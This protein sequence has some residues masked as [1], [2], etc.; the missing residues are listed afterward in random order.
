V[1]NRLIATALRKVRAAPN[2]KPR[3]PPDA[4]LTHLPAEDREIIESALP[5]SI[6]SPARVYALVEAVR[7]CVR[8]EVVGAFAECGVWRGG[9]IVA[10]IRTLQALGASDRDIYLYDT[11]E[12]MTAP[13]EADVSP[14]DR[15]ALETWQAAQRNNS[16]PW[17]EF[18]DNA[19]FNE[20]L[21]RDTL[22]ATGY[23]SERLHFVKG[24]VLETI[25]EHAAAELALLRLDT[26]WYESTRHEMLHLYPRLADGG[27]LIIDDYGHW[28][29]CR[30]AVDEYLREYAAPILL[31]RIDYT[32]RIAIKH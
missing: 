14:V 4:D 24:D 28:E 16:K 2:G 3:I 10:I 9:S 6:T 18:F 5:L 30:R 8:R 12:G 11:F 13:S 25:P 27:V 7:Y 26:D 19:V 21:V 15:S 22:A 32:G 29:G 31:N 20:D 23:P 1:A 17:G